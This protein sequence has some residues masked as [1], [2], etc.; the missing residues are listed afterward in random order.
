[1]NNDIKVNN[2][3][4]DT[5]VLNNPQNN[6]ENNQNHNF[7]INV[8][9]NQNNF[10]NMRKSVGS[11]N[12][13]INMIYPNQYNPHLINQQNMLYNVYSQN[14]HVQSYNPLNS[15]P[16]YPTQHQQNIFQK[17]QIF[18]PIN[19]INLFQQHQNL[20][21]QQ[22]HNNMNLNNHQTNKVVLD[23]ET[24]Y[25]RNSHGAKS[26]K[27]INS[28]I[29]SDKSLTNSISNFNNNLYKKNSDSNNFNNENLSTENNTNKSSFVNPQS[30]N[31]LNN[32]FNNYVSFNNY[33]NF[34]NNLFDNSSNFIPNMYVN[35]SNSFNVSK[36]IN[37]YLINNNS[38]NNSLR[39]RGKIHLIK[40]FQLF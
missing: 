28:N 20:R 16:I 11:P 31:M 25:F 30:E 18:N 2:K 22:C 24:Y 14:P 5:L 8:N 1:M 37:P 36:L 3:E 10:Y 19:N 39:H 7:G 27:T 21:N 35:N 33:P 6:F 12:A 26:N 4:K 40:S 17:P 32:Q 29:S 38:F 34:K 23:N 9:N 13:S 15:I